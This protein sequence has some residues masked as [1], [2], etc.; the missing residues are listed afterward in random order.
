MFDIWVVEAYTYGKFF[1]SHFWSFFML[2]MRLSAL[3]NINTEALYVLVLKFN[4]TVETGK[5]NLCHLFLQNR[6]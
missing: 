3:T 6:L 5:T 1:F 2:P 4:K